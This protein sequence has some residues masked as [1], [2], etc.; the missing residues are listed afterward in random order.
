MLLLFNVV[1]PALYISARSLS[2]WMIAIG[3]I[4]EIVLL[5]KLFGFGVKKSVLV[6][7]VMNFVSTI[8][9]A[10]E[11]PRLGLLA[12]ITIADPLGFSTFHP[13]MWFLNFLFLLLINTV[14][15]GVVVLISKRKRQY[16][17]YIYKVL[18]TNCIS[19]IMVYISLIVWY[20][21]I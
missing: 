14:L 7:V 4:V 1:W 18:L 16:L 5:W 3:L 19:L 17:A 12:E 15:E 21:K 2:W 6:A 11:L 9:G 20:P 13:V 10:A 8:F